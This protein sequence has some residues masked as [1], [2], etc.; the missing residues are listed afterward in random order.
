MTTQYTLDVLALNEPITVEADSGRYACGVIQTIKIAYPRV[1]TI[2][3]PAP[4][5]LPDISLEDERRTIS[6]K[7]GLLEIINAT[8]NEVPIVVYKNLGKNKPEAELHGKDAKQRELKMQANESIPIH[9]GESLTF[10][11]PAHNRNAPYCIV[12]AAY[13]EGENGEY[14]KNE[15]EFRNENIISRIQETYLSLQERILNLFKKF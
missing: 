3:R 9:P 15:G 10:G 1:L 4:N 6:R 11:I 8:P 2:G 14:K 13:K 5:N 12:Y 7:Q